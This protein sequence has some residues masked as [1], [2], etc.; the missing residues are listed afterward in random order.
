MEVKTNKIKAL[1]ARR[2]LTIKALAELSEVSR[3]TLSTTMTRK[4]CRGDTA[5]KIAKALEVD[6]MELIESED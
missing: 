5:L 2:G 3:Q 6:V 1:A 4:T